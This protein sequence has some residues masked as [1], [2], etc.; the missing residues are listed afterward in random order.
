M[1]ILWKKRNL[2][3]LGSE[4]LRV[5]GGMV[6]ALKRVGRLGFGEKVIPELLCR[7]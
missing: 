7:K 2:S 6:A 5:H 4:E 1:K 3:R